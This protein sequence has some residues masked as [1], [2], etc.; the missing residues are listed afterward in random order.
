MP[1]RG[2]IVNRSRRRG[3]VLWFPSV[4]AVRIGLGCGGGAFSLI[5]ALVVCGAFCG[6]WNLP[7]FLGSHAVLVALGP[8]EGVSECSISS[9]LVFF[10]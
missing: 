10:W 2:C 9:P 4:V 8:G 7:A 6:P 3:V 1:F 5:G